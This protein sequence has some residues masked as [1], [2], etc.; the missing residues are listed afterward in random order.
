MDPKAIKAEG[1]FRQEFVVSGIEFLCKCNEYGV[2][3]CES[4]EEMVFMMLR[5]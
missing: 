1:L 5:G 2:C 3:I 4:V